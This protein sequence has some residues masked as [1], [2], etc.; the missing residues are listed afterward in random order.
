MPE[1]SPSDIRAGGAFVAIGGRLGPL[2]KAL[3]VGES[4]LA[5]WSVRVAKL[6]LGAVGAG[7]VLG[8][9]FAVGVKAAAAFEEQMAEVEKVTDAAT[10]RA[11]ADEIRGMARDMPAT[12]EALAKI[13]ADAARFGVRGIENLKRFTQ[14]T[15]K[16]A[17]ATDL[18]AADAGMAL[19]KLTKLTD[20]STEQ[21][22]N[23]GSAINSLGNQFATSQSEVVTSSLRAG[24]ALS[25]LGLRQTEIFALSA[26]LNEVSAS[27][28]R[29]GSRLRRLSQELM[30]PGRFGQIAEA[31]GVTADQFRA[32]RQAAPLDT[33]LKLADRLR[34]GGMAAERLRGAMSSQTQQ[35]LAGLA[36][37]MAGVSKALEVSNAE[38]E[39]GTSMQREYGIYMETLAARKEKVKNKLRDVAITLGN[40]LLPAVGKA[41]DL[42]GGIIDA[43]NDW[44]Q[45]NEAIVMGVAKL[46]TGLVGVGTAL[47]ALAVG[48]KL[49]SALLSPWALLVTLVWAVADAITETELGFQQLVGSIRIGGMQI[50]SWLELAVLEAM[51][52]W[53]EFR[54]HFMR[55]WSFIEALWS[56]GWD[57]AVAVF[58]DIVDRLKIVWLQF[59]RFVIDALSGPI[60]YLLAL[61]EEIGSAIPDSMR[62]D[63]LEDLTSVN[64]QAMTAVIDEQIAE[65]EQARNDRMDNLWGEHPGA[66][67]GWQ[68]GLADID[69]RLAEQRAT[70]AEAE[71]MLVEADK[72]AGE[73]GGIIARLLGGEK[74]EWEMAFA[75]IAGG[76]DSLFADVGGGSGAEARGTFGSS[77]LGGLGAGSQLSQLLEV[78]REMADAANR[79]ADNTDNLTL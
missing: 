27:A 24:A 47:L 62:P 65:L 12:H 10:M 25:Q 19:A 39:K 7:A 75:D 73:E 32:M 43:V 14:V 45:E 67:S 36:Q 2:Q 68:E 66:V 59:S 50:S 51:R 70:L 53:E 15:A 31:V 6:G 60:E 79:T 52:I 54:A 29:S 64:A 23:M 41:L 69:E 48:V 30:D 13:A 49:V 76:L 17:V 57:G 71:R 37:N 11:M 46:A 3:M 42:F 4:M 55:V 56:T 44:I 74:G 20:T 58:K 22:E 35:A 1:G 16:M 18:A 78:N 72:K 5:A 9:P 26:A 38:F 33:I 34:Q 63:W 77:A 40:L 21:I 28:R 61:V 8:A